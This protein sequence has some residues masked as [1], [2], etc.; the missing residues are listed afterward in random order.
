MLLIYGEARGNAML[1]HGLY[2]DRFPRRRLPNERTF[3]FNVQQF[4][5]FGFFEM[6]TRYIDRQHEERVLDAEDDIL[7]EMENNS[8]ISTQRIV[9]HN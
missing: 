9:T 3:A 2:A 6:N 4:R 5:E 8:H 1:A 7:E